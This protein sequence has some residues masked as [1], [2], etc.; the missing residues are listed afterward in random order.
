MSATRR[1]L[2]NG[3]SS[4]LGLLV[5]GVVAM[6]WTRGSSAGEVT[7][8][9][10]L[11]RPRPAPRAGDAAL[12]EQRAATLRAHEAA[13]DEHRGEPVDPAWAPAQERRVR[14]LFDV[15]RGPG[16]FDVTSVGCRARTC[17]VEL[18]WASYAEARTHWEP[19]VTRPPSV[20]CAS[21]IVLPDPVAPAQRYRATAL[22]TCR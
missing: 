10:P 11:A 8:R 15:L 7:I 14:G 1:W 13:V 21:R 3:A 2:G 9:P 17:A 22:L 12:A 6:A 20:G 19:A 18:E 5:G 4:L 16:H